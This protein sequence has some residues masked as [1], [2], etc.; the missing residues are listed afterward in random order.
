MGA[1]RLTR[2]AYATRKWILSKGLS[3][4][5]FARE[6]GVDRKHVARIIDGR[7]SRVGPIIAARIEVATGGAIK[8]VWFY[9]AAVH[10]VAA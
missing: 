3:L 8:A 4:S 6:S 2:G 9:E 7:A 1:R 5:R 10:E